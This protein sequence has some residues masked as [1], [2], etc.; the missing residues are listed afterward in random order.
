MEPWL[1]LIGVL[2]GWGL[3][4]LSDYFSFRKI[5]MRS[6]NTSIFY[7]LRAWKALFD[8]ERGISYFRKNRPTIEEF[9]PWRAILAQRFLQSFGADSKTTA[10]AVKTLASVYPTLAARLDNTIKYILHTFKKDLTSLSEHDQETYAKLIYNHDQLIDFTLM[11]LEIVAKKLSGKSSVMQK[12]RVTKWLSDRKKGKLEFNES[13]QEQT[14][15]L[16]K[17]VNP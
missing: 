4:A 16:N 3:K 17:V 7:I 10:D 2:I 8:Y 11:D 6:L 13:M 5:D 9:E 12:L 14:D 15:L 1:P